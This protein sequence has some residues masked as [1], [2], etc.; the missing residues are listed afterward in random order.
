MKIK[1]KLLSCLLFFVGFMYLTLPPL[2]SHLSIE[3][4]FNEN[5]MVQVSSVNGQIELELENYLVGVLA[6]EMP[7]AFEMEA[8]KAQAVASRSYVY[9]RELKVD[10]TTSSQVYQSD[11]VLKEKWQDHYE[12]NLSKIKEAISATKGQVMTY[13]QEIIH[14]YFFS[15]SNGQ[16]NNAED[17]W[18]ASYPYL[19][20]VDSHYDEIKMDN[21]RT[22]TLS[23]DELNKIFN[24]KV[25][26]MEI[27]SRYENQY[28]KEVKVNQKSYSGRQIREM[29][30]LSSSSFHLTVNDTGITFVTLGSGHGVGMS[31]YGA[32]GMALEG[33]D[34]T[35]ILKHYY[36]GVEIVNK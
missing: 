3:N 18:T 2:T 27:I 10:D 21:E 11:E 33:Y 17:Y 34:Y 13:N 30:S 7:A 14:A 32:Q 6:S 31:Q 4:K 1:I 19:V 35:D 24:E 29:C 36:Q 5:V 12:A 26:S 16:T 20:S 9:S 8:L 28:V 23:F 25:N 15:S 22:K